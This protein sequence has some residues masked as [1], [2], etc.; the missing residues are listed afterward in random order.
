MSEDFIP[1]EL[2]VKFKEKGLNIPFFF[3][4]RTDEDGDLKIYKNRF[5]GK[6]IV[7]KR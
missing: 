2:A 3:F 1:F 6:I 5:S 7:E 4:Y